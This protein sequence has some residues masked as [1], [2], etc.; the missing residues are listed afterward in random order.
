MEWILILA[1]IKWK[2]ILEVW[3]LQLLKF[4]YLHISLQIFIILRIFKSKSKI[5]FRVDVVSCLGDFLWYYT[6]FLEVLFQI[7][8]I[9]FWKNH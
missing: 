1:N 8:L 7:T 6:S 4:S 5:P 9:F 3:N 2:F